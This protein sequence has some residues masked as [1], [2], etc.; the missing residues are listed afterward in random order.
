MGPKTPPP[1]RNVWQAAASRPT[2]DWHITP[3]V[4]ERGDLNAAINHPNTNLDG[5]LAVIDAAIRRQV[6][7]S[8]VPSA[9]IFFLGKELA[10]G[11]PL[12][13]ALARSLKVHMPAEQ[14]VESL[15]ERINSTKVF[16]EAVTAAKFLLEAFGLTPRHDRFA[17]LKAFDL[18]FQLIQHS[19]HCLAVKA[20]SRIDEQDR[21]TYKRLVGEIVGLGDEARP[22][23]H[24]A[25]FCQIELTGQKEH[26]RRDIGLLLEQLL[27][28]QSADAVLKEGPIHA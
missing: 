27:L 15:G 17:K 19:E 25:R 11:P 8:R 20:E 28:G 1:V 3:F 9:V 24:K 10:Y 18:I 16:S 13:T 2:S 6:V 5:Q 21:T 12:N 4:L 23:L 14:L 22:A 26:F 7:F